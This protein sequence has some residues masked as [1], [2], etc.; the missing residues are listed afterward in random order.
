[1]KALT[2]NKPGKPAEFRK[3]GLETNY[4]SLCVLNSFSMKRN[5][6]EIAIEIKSDR[7]NPAKPSKNDDDL[8]E[9]DSF[10][11]LLKEIDNTCITRLF[12]DAFLAL[13]GHDAESRDT[14]A[15][16]S[17]T[18]LRFYRN[19]G[20]KNEMARLLPNYFGFKVR[21]SLIIIHKIIF[22]EQNTD[23][24]SIWRSKTKTTLQT[25]ASFRAFCFL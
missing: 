21:I 23:M 8:S 19:A 5:M 10:L 12:L 24:M 13:K 22:P 15:V 25:L 1:V 2:Q 17:E 16:V 3:T 4:Y 11:G 6:I 7:F 9:T 20:R 14:K 18:W